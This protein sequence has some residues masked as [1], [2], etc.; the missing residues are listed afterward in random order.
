M[1]VKATTVSLCEIAE[2]CN[3]SDDSYNFIITKKLEMHRVYAKFIPHSMLDEQK[4]HRVNICQEIL[5]MVI[6]DPTFLENIITGN[7]IRVYGYN[8]EMK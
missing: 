3:I 8:V 2:E 7:E 4:A 5:E 6:V 1:S